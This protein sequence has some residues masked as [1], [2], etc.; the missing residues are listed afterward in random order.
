MSSPR[1]A[2]QLQLHSARKTTDTCCLLPGFTTASAG[3]IVNWPTCRAPSGGGGAGGAA[4]AALATAAP[5][6]PARIRHVLQNSQEP[7]IQPYFTASKVHRALWCCKKVQVRA[8][9]NQTVG[10]VSSRLLMRVGCRTRQKAYVQ[11][12]APTA[13]FTYLCPFVCQFSWHLLLQPRHGQ[14]SQQQLPQLL[15]APA[16]LA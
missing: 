3:S 1:V 16:G 13:A 8:W 2:A 14:L 15:Q 9:K 6:R 12:L 4:A 11:G 10:A 7:I 5:L